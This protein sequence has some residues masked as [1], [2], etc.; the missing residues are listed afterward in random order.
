MK[1]A[2]PVEDK[3]MESK[4]ASSFG[5]APYF[6][7][8]ESERKKAEFIDNSAIASQGGAGIKAAQTIVDSGAKILI[9]PQCGEKAATVIQEAKIDIYKNETNSILETID[10]FIN[11][12]LSKLDEIHPGYHN[13]GGR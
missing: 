9:T 3:A 7:V 6:L 2:M 5:R 8:Y 12:N 10:A 1:I 13:H 4:V 11:G